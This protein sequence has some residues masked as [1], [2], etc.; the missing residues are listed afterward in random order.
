MKTQPSS[1]SFVRKALLVPGLLLALVPGCSNQSDLDQTRLIP[2]QAQLDKAKPLIAARPFDDKVPDSYDDSRSWPLLV[3]LHGHGANSTIQDAYFGISKQVSTLGFLYAYPD[4][5]LDSTKKQF[6]NATDVC[7]N[8]DGKDV[9]DV[10]YLDAVIADMASR[11]NVDKKRIYLMGHSNG[12]FMSHRYAC[13]RSELVAGFVSLAGDNYKDTAMYCKP[14]SPVAMLQVHGTKD[15]AVPYEG[16]TLGKQ[17]LP[18]ALETTRFWAGVGGCDQTGDTTAP[19]IDLEPDLA[20]AE[21]KVTRFGNCQKGGAA[22]LWT[23]EG[24]SHVPN[25]YRPGWIEKTW[26]YLAQNPKK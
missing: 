5:N 1:L 22:E 12:G 10:A 13:E 21:T 4:G 24:G 8:F 9:D 19:R 7:C 15:E 23:I 18:S 16:G 25:L 14:T 17:S 11:Y 2:T 6:W 3:M 26:A 20:D